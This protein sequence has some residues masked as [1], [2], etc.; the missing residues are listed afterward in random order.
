MDKIFM[1][2][3]YENPL[4]GDKDLNKMI[5]KLG[6]LNKLAHEDLIS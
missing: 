4:E 3:E 1:Q 2:D 6:E 5:L